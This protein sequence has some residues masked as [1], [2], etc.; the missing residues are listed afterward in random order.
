[1]LCNDSA[2][3]PY[4]KPSLKSR[5]PKSVRSPHQAF[6]STR[7]ETIDILTAPDAGPPN[8]LPMGSSS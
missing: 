3:L 6:F 1:V 5:M 8:S 4:A 7:F 2:H